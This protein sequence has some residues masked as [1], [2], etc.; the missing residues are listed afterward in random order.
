MS[1]TQEIDELYVHY[2]LLNKDLQQLTHYSKKTYQTLKKYITLKERLDIE[3]Y[4]LLDN[5]KEL[6]QDIAL[7]LCKEI[8]NPNIQIQLYPT[9]K[10]LTTKEKK[11][12]IIDSKQCDICI[13]S[14][15]ISEVLPC[16]GNI[17]CFHCLLSIIESSIN[18]IC[19]QMVRC[20]YCREKIPLKFI[21]DIVRL[22]KTSNIRMGRCSFEP[23]RNTAEYVDITRNYGSFY[24]H[25]LYRKYHMIYT[26]LSRE[27]ITMDTHHYGYCHKCIRDNYRTKD[28]FMKKHKLRIIHKLDKLHIARIPKRC[29]EDVEI[30]DTMFICNPCRDK[31]VIIKSC[32]H[33]GIKSLQPDGCNYVR[34]ECGEYWCFVCNVRLPGTHEGHNVHFWMGKGTSAFDDHCRMSK[35]YKAEKHILQSC[36]CMY[37]SERQGAPV[38]MNIDCGRPTTTR[39][40]YKKDKQGLYYNQLCD[41]CR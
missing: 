21:R 16:C 22:N 32:P 36:K 2:S 37:C 24:L 35:D 39:K 27:D 19:F 30:K 26:E 12:K 29:A 23:W 38:C 15:T 1:I 6:T 8:L 5:R 4:P 40:E 11:A 9:L 17:I 20:P 14:R 33:C 41:V 10:G 13:N 25:N 34:C 7:T 31:K 18:G 3:L 28:N